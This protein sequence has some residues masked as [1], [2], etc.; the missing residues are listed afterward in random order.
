DVRRGFRPLECSVVPQAD[1]E[2]P[3]SMLR[4]AVL[5]AIEY[6]R[7]HG[8]SE[9]LEGL[10]E[11]HEY[12]SVVPARKIR[13]V[14]DEYRARPQV[15]HHGHEALPELRAR[16]LGAATSRGDE[17]PD[18]RTAGPRERLAWRSACDE[19]DVRYPPAIEIADQLRRVRKVTD[20]SEPTDVR[21]V[22]LHR[23]RV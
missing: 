15:F 1:E 4:N 20:V 23:V 11:A 12:A 5:E 14:L 6:A 3:R 10:V 21:L 2:Q 22:R 8:V 13:D 9:V 7:V 17:V 16:I 18:H 19:V